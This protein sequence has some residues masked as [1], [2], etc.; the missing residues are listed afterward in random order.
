MKYILSQIKAM[1][2]ID[3]SKVYKHKLTL[4]P[5]VPYCFPRNIPSHPQ[6]K[7]SSRNLLLWHLTIRHFTI[8]LLSFVLS[9]RANSLEMGALVARRLCLGIPS[10]NNCL[11]A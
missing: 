11:T 4:L 1:S 2:F 5:A 7:L 3:N 6:E 8:S 10:S 9:L